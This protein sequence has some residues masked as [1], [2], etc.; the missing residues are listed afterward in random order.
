[1]PD[2]RHLWNWQLEMNMWNLG[3]LQK[4]HMFAFFFWGNAVFPFPSF[5][6]PCAVT[7]TQEIPRRWVKLS[8]AISPLIKFQIS[9]IMWDHQYLSPK[10]QTNK[11]K[12]IPFL[13]SS[14]PSSRK[15]P[16]RSWRFPD[17]TQDVA[18][19]LEA[20]E[21]TASA[22]SMASS[23]YRSWSWCSMA[24]WAQELSERNLSI[25]FPFSSKK[26]S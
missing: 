21:S 16:H 6:L 23:V 12:S 18:R 20:S 1:M 19:L 8:G 22:P 24:W 25:V 5:F 4:S 7:K 17:K 9:E 26:V 2:K 11:Q 13:S 15:K 3:Q 10:D 14:H